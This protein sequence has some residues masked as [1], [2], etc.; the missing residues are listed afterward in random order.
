MAAL[1]LLCFNVVLVLLFMINPTNG[2]ANEDIKETCWEQCFRVHLTIYKQALPNHSCIKQ[3]KA[4]TPIKMAVYY[5]K[6]G[7][8]PYFLII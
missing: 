5:E 4:H 8:K 1:W 3:E 6:L 2:L 7:F